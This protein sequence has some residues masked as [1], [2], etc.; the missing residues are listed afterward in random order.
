M[1]RRSS[2]ERLSA[3]ARAKLEQKVDDNQESILELVEWIESEH[4]VTISKSAMGR[5]VQRRKRRAAA[6]RLMAD[7]SSELGEEGNDE[8]VELMMQLA[9][10][11]IQEA[12]ILER[13]KTIGAI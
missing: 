6:V 11:R 1:A 13:L 5:F 4:G 7:V 3:E 8:A 2:I 10:I 9:H 12:R